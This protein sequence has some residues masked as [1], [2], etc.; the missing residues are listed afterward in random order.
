MGFEYTPGDAGVAGNDRRNAIRTINDRIMELRESQAS[1]R[2]LAAKSIAEKE[3]R[4]T[5]LEAAKREL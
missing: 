4:I 3:A 1:L 5:L 2:R